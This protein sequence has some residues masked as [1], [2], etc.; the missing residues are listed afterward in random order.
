MRR[1]PLAGE[2]FERVG[3]ER[4]RV[5]HADRDAVGLPPRAR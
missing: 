1:T 3:D 5:A 4:R 2:R